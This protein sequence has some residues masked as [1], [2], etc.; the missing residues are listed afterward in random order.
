MTPERVAN[1]WLF[2]A[3]CDLYFAFDCD[4]DI[5]EDY[6]RFSEIM[7][8]EKFLKALLLFHRHSEYE[9]L[10]DSDARKKIDALAKNIGHKFESMLTE[11][12][13]LGAVSIPQI[14]DQ[15]WDGYLGKSLVEAVYAGYMET[16]YPVPVPISNSFP[17]PVPERAPVEYS[18]FTHDPLSSSGITKFI[19]AICNCCFSTLVSQGLQPEK[20]L[21]QFDERFDGREAFLRFKNCFW[22]QRLPDARH[23]H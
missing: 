14:L 13:Q 5:F 9:T 10:S 2:R 22:D 19:Y 17:I 21:A 18:G 4:A 7:G 16:R 1:T 3:L 15:D 23:G 20:M 12:A 11:A 6:A 8:M